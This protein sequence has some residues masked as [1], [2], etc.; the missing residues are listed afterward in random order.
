MYESITLHV[1]W[2]F[3][4][5]LSFIFYWY[6]YNSMILCHGKSPA[7]LAPKGGIRYVGVF[8]PVNYL[9]T[10]FLP[11]PLAPQFPN[12]K[13][14]CNFHWNPAK[15]IYQSSGPFQQPFPPRK[16]LAEQNTFNV[17]ICILGPISLPVFQ[18]QIYHWVHCP[19]LSVL[20]CCFPG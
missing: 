6:F 7:M 18:G 12:I 2:H 4:Y 11:H 8:L 19:Q 10:P 15:C 20:S 17:V 9:S 16:K 3:F 13:Q 14:L 5:S 1:L